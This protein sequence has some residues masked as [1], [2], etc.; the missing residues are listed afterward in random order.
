[1]TSILTV[2]CGQSSA[3]DPGAEREGSMV[4]SGV[5]KPGPNGAL[6]IEG[7]VADV[8]LRDASGQEVGRESG[9]GL[10]RFEDL[11]P[12]QCTIEPAVRPC[13]GNCGYL[14]PRTDQCSDSVQVGKGVVRL[15][16][17]Y[18]VGVPCRVYSEP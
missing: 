7:S 12:G 3:D 17:V 10:L 6:Y 15:R 16:V 11:A 4:V 14:D 8:I 2:A 13:E 9:N 18:R 1:V 5:H